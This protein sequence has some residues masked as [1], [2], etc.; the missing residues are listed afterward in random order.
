MEPEIIDEL[1]V[2]VVAQE[3]E[4]KK[5]TVE[6]GRVR[7]TKEVRERVEEIEEPLA[8]ERV[9]VER[10]AID[11]VVTEP[12]AT[13]QEGDTLIVPVVEEVLVIEKRLVLKEELRI[14]RVRSVEP[15]PPV[16][17]T[18]RSEDV[19]VERVPPREGDGA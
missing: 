7:I 3:L 14:T 2:P 19:R 15:S 18:L 5:R 12:P 10:V 6:S 13:R 11:Q 17:V 16:H 8:R 9:F 4:V 1:I